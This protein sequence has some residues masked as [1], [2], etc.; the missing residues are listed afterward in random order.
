MRSKG[1]LSAVDQDWAIYRA[2]TILLQRCSW[3]E[4]QRNQDHMHFS[5]LYDNVYDL[6]H[7]SLRILWPEVLHSCLLKWHLNLG[8]FS[9]VFWKKWRAVRTRAPPYF[10]NEVMGLWHHKFPGNELAGVGLSLSHLSSPDLT[11]MIFLFGAHE[12]C[13]EYVTIGYHFATSRWE[14]QKCSAYSYPQ[15]A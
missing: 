5:W 4:R 14:D 13:C 9:C 6:Y 1:V 11:P 15:L 10:H 7:L 3:I 12:G 8:N 2:C